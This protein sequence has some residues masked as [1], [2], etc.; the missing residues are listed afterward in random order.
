MMNKMWVNYSYIRKSTDEEDRQILSLQGQ[1]QTVDSLATLQGETIPSENQYNDSHSAKSANKRPNFSLMISKVQKE[2]GNGK[3]VR[4][5]VWKANRLSRNYSEGG[6]IADWVKDGRAIVISQTKT[7]GEYDSEQLNDEFTKATGFSKD[8]S[9]DVTRGLDTKVAM[10]WRPGRCPVGYT[11]DIYG[12]KGAKRILIDFER[13]ELVKE[14]F[15]LVAIGKS[16]VSALKIVTGKG[17]TVKTKNGNKSISTKQSYKI[18]R[19]PFYYG[20]FMWKG[21]L[22]KGSHQPL[23]TKDLWDQVQRV[24]D[25][26]HF[27]HPKQNNYFF[28]RLLKCAK[29]N[30]FVTADVQKG[31]VYTK[32]KCKGNKHLK[33]KD[34]NKQVVDLIGQLKT[35]PGFVQWY[36]DTLKEVNEEEF[37]KIRSTKTLQTKRQDAILAELKQLSALKADGLP[38]EIYLKDKNKLFAEL[39]T[40]K[41]QIVDSTDLNS[42]IGDLERLVNF[43]TSCKELFDDGDDDTKRLVAN[44]IS[45]S[46]LTLDNGIV[47]VQAKKAFVFLK[48]KENTSYVKNGLVELQNSFKKGTI[49]QELT[50]GAGKHIIV[51]L[52][53]ILKEDKS[54]TD[55][56]F[57]GLG[58][59]EKTN[60]QFNYA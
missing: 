29:C 30:H 5:F 15:N 59:L 10:G 31:N 57:L 49:P 6:I 4:F 23:V 32:C 25:G 7:Y 8:L 37:E 21:E 9:V 3:S 51:E 14:Y 58:L 52:L 17:L 47:R 11:N 26:R 43:S 41:N 33:L 42:W 16:V 13:A 22:K 1:K 20:N 44:L 45:R 48:N 46:N 54:E 60:Q 55:D 12:L 27:A 56:L 18:L 38:E 19:N 39:E 50:L 2:I 24:L 40:I 28:M 34:V 53:N 35:T 36:I